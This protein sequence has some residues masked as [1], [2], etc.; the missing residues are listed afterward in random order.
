MQHGELKVL[1]KI[2]YALQKISPYDGL[3]EILERRKKETGRNQE[4]TAY[5][6]RQKQT[7]TDR[8]LPIWA[9]HR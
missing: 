5:A 9:M 7:L 4:Q 1:Q 3:N 2:K 8:I 6:R